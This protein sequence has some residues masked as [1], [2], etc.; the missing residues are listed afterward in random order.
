MKV[1]VLEENLSSKM[2]RIDDENL[3]Q[4]RAN[5]AATPPTDQDYRLF[6]ESVDEGF[7]IIEVL[8]DERGQAVDWRYLETNPVFEKYTGL[9]GVAG[10]RVREVI[11]TIE[12][13]WIDTYARVA[14]TGEA[15]RYV[16]HV[17]ELDRWFEVSAVRLGP[18]DTH[19]LAVLFNDVTVYKRTE[20]ALRT[21]ESQLQA[22]VANLPGGAVF[23]VDRDLR[24]TL[25][26]GE[27]LREL[28]YEASDLIG[29]TIAE[30][31]DPA[32]I[33]EHE[34]NY[35]RALAGHV[36]VQEH[37]NRGRT[38]LTRGLPLS[39]PNGDIYAVLAMS[40]DIT[41]RKRSEEALRE[42]EA[43]L[44]DLFTT[45]DEGYSLC[46]M[47]VDA[48][49][50]PVDYRFLEV[51]P[52]FEAMTGLVGAVGRTA[53]ELV[54]NLERHWVETYARVGLGGETLRFENG[55]EAMGRW[56]D[57]FAAPVLPRGRFAL[58]FKDITEQKRDADAIRIAAE[59]SRFRVAL[60][61]RL[62]S[63]TDPTT[64]QTETSWL[65]GEHLGVSRAFYAQVEAD[66]EY[67]IIGHDY[68]DGVASA[69]GRYRLQDFGP[70]VAN[71]IRAGQTLVVD[72]VDD[73]ALTDAEAAMFASIDVRAHLTVCLV[74]EDRPVALLG[75][76]QNR[77]RVW[78]VEEQA[79]V[80]ETAERTWAAV[81]RVR[82]EAAL[83][84]SEQRFRVVLQHLPSG[85][86]MADRHGALVYGNPEVERI[87]RGPFIYSKD[88]AS[89]G[90]WPLY[91]LDVDEPFPLERMPMT[92]SL[93]TGEVVVGEEM[94]IRWPNGEWRY[95]AVNTAP[96]YDADGQIAYAVA[97][98]IDVTERKR[99]E[100][101]R[102]ALLEREQRARQEAERATAMQRLFLGM[103][104]HELRTPLASIKGFSS[105]LL[106]T[107]VTFE[108]DQ[109][110]EF[111]QV[112]DDEADKLTELIDQLLNVVRLQAGTLG[113]TPVPVA[114]RAIVDEALSQLKMLAGQR[115]LVVRLA[116]PLPLVMADEQRICQVLLNLVSNAAKF[117]PAHTAITV[118]ARRDGSMVQIAVS[119]EGDGIPAAE[120]AQVFEAFH[121]VLQK[122]GRQPG[123]GLGLAICKGLV[124][125]HGGRIWVVERDG[126]GTTIAFTLPLAPSVTLS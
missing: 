62:R 78:T 23:V 118:S 49:G 28:G 91:Q 85:V 82:V 92:R 113:V 96:V 94:R 121:Q 33:A 90:D 24:Y 27:A 69:A 71:A 61:D 99:I 64:I 34:Y 68:A 53:L 111:L 15:V 84:E 109:Q 93:T 4:K 12:T 66:G 31:L 83:R 7:C 32:L 72:D 74:K 38:F 2:Q 65:L 55:S 50:E 52:L 122:G 20:Q 116:E 43:R 47:V 1:S 126:P 63:L 13:H 119:D 95:A 9:T 54:P 97:T 35:R 115:D 6:F 106:A 70:T 77:P 37:E 8:Y 21:S 102:A 26:E 44:R 29:K 59:Q 107:D 10:K 101:E 19:R 58:V 80:E 86:I 17:A 30:A 125:A 60:T 120:R 67:V 40:Y 18:P 98:F 73:A 16:N 103:V 5:D 124:E 25:A 88:A 81:E 117:S 114:V 75:L 104:S 46:E 39:D 11:P 108:A 57:V 3:Q 56:F 14:E 41:E 100:V 48:A 36:F 112:I 79:L 87:F 123:T 76:H 22:L 45:I 51:N 89:Y 42:R 110:Q 105:S